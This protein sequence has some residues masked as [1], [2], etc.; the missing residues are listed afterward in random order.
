MSKANVIPRMLSLLASVLLLSPL[1]SA[2]TSTP[3]TV[4]ATYRVKP[5]RVNAFLELMPA[6]WAALRSNNLVLEGPHVVLR[7]DQHGKP[8]IVEIFSWEG[9]RCPGARSSSDSALLG[10]HQ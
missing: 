2:Q 10:P 5:E 8:V 7:G 6:Y 1:C 9:P 4:L 3:E